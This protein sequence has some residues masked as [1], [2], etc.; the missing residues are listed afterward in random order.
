MS[1]ICPTLEA[2]MAY[3]VKKNTKYYYIRYKQNGRWVKKSLKTSDHRLAKRALLE[4]QL[5]ETKTVLHFIT[6]DTAVKKLLQDYNTATIDNPNYKE[7]T[8]KTKE[9]EKMVLKKLEE[10]CEAHNIVKIS[11]FTTAMAK[12][13]QTERSKSAASSTVNREMTAIASFFNF[14]VSAG[15]INQNPAHGLTTLK[16]TKKIFRY[17]S[18][19]EIKKLFEAA[20]KHKPWWLPAIGMG[21]YAG[22][23]KTEALFCE[24]KDVDLEKKIIYVKW[25]PG[26]DIKDRE[27]RALPM[28]GNLTKI[29]AEAIKKKNSPAEVRTKNGTYYYDLIFRTRDGKFHRNNFDKKFKKL[30]KLAGLENVTFQT[31]RETFGSHLLSKITGPKGFYLVSK[32]L[33]HSSIRVTEKHYASL[34]L[35]K[36]HEEVDKLTDF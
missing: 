24:F 22:F 30:V 18:A 9:L 4:Y 6:I 19:E 15:Y 16:T 10:F 21:Y 3:L 1:H 20:K 12:L 26:M 11:Q 33:G 23:R 17:M 7:K 13:Y 25:K 29:I 14:A 34:D 35:T 36:S 5:L 28:S 2:P 27:E 32:F 8:G 31:L